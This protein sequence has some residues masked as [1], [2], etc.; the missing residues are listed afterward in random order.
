[1]YRAV[2]LLCLLWGFNWVV[3]KVATGYFSP[4]FFSMLRFTSGA[5]I[6]FLVILAKRISLPAKKYWPWIIFTGVTQI[7]YC[8]AAMQTALV[9]LGSG[10]AAMLNYTMP[11]WTAILARLF[12]KE[13]LS[14]L[15]LMGITLSLLGL[16][17][18]LN[19]NVSGNIGAVLLALSAAVVWGAGNVAMKGK[20]M[21][22]DLTALTACQMATGA[23][24][25]LPYALLVEEFSADWNLT[26]LLCA[27]Y[28]GVL[29]SALAFLLWCYIIR[30]ME[31]GKAA[32]SILAAPVVGVLG[33]VICL[34]ETMT[35]LMGAGMLLVFAGIFLSQRA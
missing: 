20:L 7:A 9:D 5:A 25:L 21:G 28:N 14:W 17:V 26:S 13:R 3:M 16:G 34:G 11:V 12:L 4:A 10:M 2:I 31:A 32:V 1:M 19:V 35:P 22:C 24:V 23:L 27:A 33:G 30:N 29:A 8:N 6:L 18:L 15:R